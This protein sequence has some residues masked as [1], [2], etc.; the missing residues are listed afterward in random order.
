MNERVGLELDK[1]M[2]D[3]QALQIL[4]ELTLLI[5]GGL[6]LLVDLLFVPFRRGEE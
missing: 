1:V 5:V 4:P 2:R 3:P 6:L